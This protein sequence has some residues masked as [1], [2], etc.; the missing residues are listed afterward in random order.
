[1]WVVISHSFATLISCRIQNPQLIQTNRNSMLAHPIQKKT[2]YLSDNFRRLVID[3]EMVFI[4][5]ILSISIGCERS[6]K[7][8]FSALH[9]KG[10]SDIHGG[11]ACIAVVHNA[12]DGNLIAV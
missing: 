4:F 2:K 5:R 9:V 11:T 7:L 3:Q 10:A 8:S 12:A 6:N 1:M